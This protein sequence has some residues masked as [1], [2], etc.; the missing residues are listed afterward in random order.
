M[1]AL[2]WFTAV[3]EGA[4][5]ASA[6]RDPKRSAFEYE[7]G[8]KTRSDVDRALYW[9]HQF[10]REGDDADRKGDRRAAS[11]H[12]EAARLNRH[13]AAWLRLYGGER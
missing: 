4:S 7:F 10:A 9:G 2:E 13:E 11:E 6:G 3:I 12:R 8:T 1:K 5:V